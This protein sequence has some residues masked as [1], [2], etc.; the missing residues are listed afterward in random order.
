VAVKNGQRT[1]T[2]GLHLQW[3]FLATLDVPVH[4]I[5]FGG[6]AGGAIA[7][8][9][10][11]SATVQLLQGVAKRPEWNVYR[12]GLPILG[13]DGTLAEAV[14]PESPARGKVLAKTGTLFA[15]DVMNDRALLR[16]K[17]LAGTMTT[18]KGRT[19][20][21]AMF[22]NSV[23]LPKKETPQREGKVL[24]KLCEIIYQHAP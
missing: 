22:V 21:F 5:S 2:A 14:A 17:A 19:L 8:L 16:S 3:R 4:T 24:G 15:E 12:D 1:L 11:P 6:G 13:V 7:D 18:A 20:F 23:P 10:T 9:T